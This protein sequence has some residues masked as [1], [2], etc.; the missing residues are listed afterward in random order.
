[1]AT[2][3]IKGIRSS[4]LDIKPEICAERA[5]YY[6]ES[7]KETEAQ[8]MILRRAKALANTLRHMTI[9]AR[10]GELIA[11]N[12]A[13]KPKAAPL[14]P[15]YSM[16]WIVSELNEFEKRPSDPFTISEDTK[17]ELR[18]LLKYWVG[19]T[20]LD[21]VKAIVPEIVWK[22]QEMG[23]ITDEWLVEG[24]FGNLIA[25]YETLFKIGLNGY[26]KEA[27]DHLNSLDLLNPDD[28]R[29]INFLQAAIVTLEAVIDFAKRYSAELTK[30][31]QS[32]TDP[33][34]KAELEQMAENCAQ[35]PAGPPR[36]FW[37]ALQ[38]MFIVHD[39]IQIEG[40]G[41]S[42]SIGRFDQTLYPFYK[43]DV[44][45]GKLTREFALELVESFFLKCNEL[46]KIRKWSDTE[47]FRGYPLFQNLM[48]G[49]QTKYGTDATNELSW[50][51]LDATGE[52]R[53]FAPSVSLRF[54]KKLNDDFLVRCVEVMNTHRGGMPAT[55]NDDC[56]IPALLYEGV[57][58]EDAYNYAIVGC[59]ESSVP[60]K[61][62]FSAAK[63]CQTNLG[64]VME[65]ALRNG[66]DPRSGE[67]LC[68]GDGDLS[69]F[70]SF[71]EVMEAF[72]K[73]LKFFLEHGL[74]LDNLNELAHEELVPNAFVS[75]VIQDCIKR[76]KSLDEGGAVYDV[77]GG[78]AQGI[79]TVADSLAAIKK[80]VFDEKW[81][82]AA[83]L[84]H[85]LDTDFEDMD[86]EPSGEEIRQ[87]LRNR[88]P[89]YGNDDDYVDMIAIDIFKYYASIYEKFK[90]LRYG[91]GPIGGNYRINTSG[92]TANVAFGSVVGATPDGRKGGKPLNNG[93]SPSNGVEVNGP[94][95][96]IK[97]VAKLPYIHMGGGNIFNVK[98]N[99]KMFES[100]E[101]CVKLASLIR[102]FCDLKGYHI[103]FNIVDAKTLKKAQES[104]EEYRDLV[105]RVAGY[106]AY[107]TTIDKAVQD[108]IISRAEFTM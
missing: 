50:I 59:S 103:Q 77:S 4:L 65:L 1:M 100:R 53:L 39:C 51:V 68:P 106:S 23:L 97:S 104:P 24:G 91:K 48:I 62:G 11:G 58:A 101:G 67:Q 88:V 86:T 15:E 7:M 36:T 84:K 42:I 55:Y 2:Q 19:K 105:V 31:A 56:I 20:N 46:N 98:M 29:K 18:E 41:H 5:R 3:R 107:F 34:R 85:A 93:V 38:A 63:G 49:G 83:Q 74:M 71:D 61:W 30:L 17:E 21:R 27:K 89:K 76:G 66:V 8:P 99:P 94:S 43:K 79:A 75:A 52:L 108:D 26:L 12:Q 64:K 54:H 25:D 95:A 6:T 10:D 47:F 70:K 90:C 32:E 14:F 69:T 40:N 87:M 37:E 33:G 57:N 78:P 28:V 102:A 13:S 96:A 73:Q 92:V 60:G 16:D 81:L 35:T 80:A 72:K 44:E 82:T 45:A 22:P 9:Y